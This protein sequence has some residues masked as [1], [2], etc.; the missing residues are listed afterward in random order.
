MRVEYCAP[1]TTKQRKAK[2]QVPVWKPYLPN[3]IRAS[4]DPH[5]FAAL[6]DHK[7]ISR[8]IIEIGPHEWALWERWE[9]S[10]MIAAEHAQRSYVKALHG[11]SVYICPY[12]KGEIL[13]MKSGVMDMLK[14]EFDRAEGSK[15]IVSHD[16][17]GRKVPMRVR[18]EDVER[19][20]A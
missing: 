18:P 11:G 15:L 8:R 2:A 4:I 14:V 9:L 1:K 7:H 6:K 19:A 5:D 3:F 10:V 13:R 17:M 16:M 12:Q 20:E